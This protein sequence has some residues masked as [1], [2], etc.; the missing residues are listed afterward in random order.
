MSPTLPM[1]LLGLL[2]LARHAVAVL[3]MLSS[4]MTLLPPAEPEYASTL[5]RL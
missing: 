5:L 3:H 2:P 1:Q 4:T